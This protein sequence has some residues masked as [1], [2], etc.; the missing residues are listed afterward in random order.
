MY[1]AE[2]TISGLIEFDA[3]EARIVLQ[4]RCASDD[5]LQATLISLAQDR[6]HE[7]GM[8]EIENAA[9]DDI[10]WGEL[11]CEQA[12]MFA[13][14]NTLEAELLLIYRRVKSR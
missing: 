2:D 3:Q 6:M 14:F 8:H 12:E 1:P 11:D 7:I 9:G 13:D 10:D 4:S 5:S